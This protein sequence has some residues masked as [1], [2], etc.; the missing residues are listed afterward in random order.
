MSAVGWRLL[1]ALQLLQLNPLIQNLSAELSAGSR[2]GTSVLQVQIT[3]A[4][5]FHAQLALDN[6]RSPGVGSFR[7]RVQLNEANL[8]GLGDNISL[9]YSNTD[10]SNTFDTSYTLPL[11]PRNGTIS[12][13]FGTASSNVIEEPFNTLDIQ[14][15]S[16]YYEITYRQPLA[17]SPS[18]E[19]AIGLTASRRES[20][21]YSSL[22][23]A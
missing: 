14:S 8:L 5:S 21:I 22:F 15:S 3:E 2:P 1:E 18:Q 11:N 10:G 17:Q 6:G 20:E 23:T 19:F 13:N 7:R 4:K 16:R 12:F 9:A